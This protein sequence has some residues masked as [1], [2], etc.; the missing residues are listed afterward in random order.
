MSSEAP[1]TEV[2]KWSD[3]L[4]KRPLGS[5]FHVQMRCLLCGNLIGVKGASGP[6][7]L[8]AINCPHC[9]QKLTRVKKEM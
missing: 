9:G 7:R 6:Q 1:F 8:K 2:L 3:D 5:S 4:L